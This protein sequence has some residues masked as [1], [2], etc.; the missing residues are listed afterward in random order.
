M[1]DNLI[2]LVKEN[3]QNIV[4]N[5]PNIPNDNNNDVI[6]ETGST[7]IDELKNAVS[8]GNFSSVMDIFSNKEGILE[9]PVVGNIINSLTDTLKSKF[10]IDGGEAN[11]VASRLVPEVVNQMATKT[12]EPIDNGF[13]LQDILNNVGANSLGD[14]GGMIGRFTSSSGKNENT[15]EGGMI[16]SFF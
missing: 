5:N 16:K 14:I 11:N 9:N 6:N 7:I 3:A 15:G 8:Q 4:V 12:N 10:D 1:L 2:N 13:D